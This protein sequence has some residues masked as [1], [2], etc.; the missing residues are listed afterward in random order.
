MLVGAIVPFPFWLYC[1][2]YPQSIVRHINPS[3]VF[4]VCLSI[5]P[6]SGVNIASFLVVGF[7]FQF[8]IR[9]YYFAWWARYNYVL[10][11]SLDVGTVAGLLVIFLCLR[12]P[13]ADLV[14]WGNTVYT[15]TTDWTGE[16]RDP[17]PDGKDYFGPDTWKL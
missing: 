2:R 14:W 13:K 1:R 8:W 12:L 5:P 6:A 11:A 3:I 7:V 16:A 15:R 9:R 17:L 4:A 10:S